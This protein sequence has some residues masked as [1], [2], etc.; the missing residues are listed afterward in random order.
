ML[1]FDPS[2]L[3]P[4][5]AAGGWSC[6]DLSRHCTGAA[7]VRGPGERPLS[8]RLGEALPLCPLEAAA[9][10]LGARGQS[11]PWR[12]NVVPAGLLP[13]PGRCLP[14]AGPAS[15]RR[16][17]YAA[18][19]PPTPGRRP[20]APRPWAQ[21]AAACPADAGLSP[22]SRRD[23]CRP[24]ARG[25]FLGPHSCSV[26]EPGHER[27]SASP[28]APGGHRKGHVASIRR[29]SGQQWLGCGSSF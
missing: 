6:R 9:L 20:P 28:T 15:L 21:H 26:V 10:G 7:S 27:T 8:L 4:E 3:A 19:K 16:G 24:G 17:R 29:T 5:S 2:H 13:P 23:H 1:G 22:G 18:P 25:H 11:C 14:C 12:G